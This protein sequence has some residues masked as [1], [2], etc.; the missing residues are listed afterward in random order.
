MPCI[1]LGLVL[2]IPFPLGGIHQPAFCARYHLLVSIADCWEEIIEGILACATLCFKRS[3]CRIWLSDMVS[4]L[5]CFPAVPVSRCCGRK[6][7]SPQ[8]LCSDLSADFIGALAFLP[9]VE[10]VGRGTVPGCIWL[11]RR[12]C[13]KSEGL[14]HTHCQLLKRYVSKIPCAGLDGCTCLVFKFFPSPAWCYVTWKAVK[15]KQ[16]AP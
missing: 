11:F 6:H 13:L 9:A 1:T 8:G 2:E 3:V 5:E 15:L 16:S 10:A 4:R 7:L 14:S 12:T